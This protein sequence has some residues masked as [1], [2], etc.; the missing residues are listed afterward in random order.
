MG[1]GTIA[2]GLR[3]LPLLWFMYCA[4]DL[5]LHRA[6]SGLVLLMWLIRSSDHPRRLAS[7]L[8]T[9]CPITR[10]AGFTRRVPG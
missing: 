4:P 2:R 8:P 6:C 7:S 1:L 10:E 9:T 5:S 3:D